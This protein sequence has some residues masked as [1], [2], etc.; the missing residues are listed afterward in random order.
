M[1]CLSC[2]IVRDTESVLAVGDSID[3]YRVGI[4]VIPLHEVLEVPSSCVPI[5][6]GLLEEVV[7]RVKVH[8]EDS[9]VGLIYISDCLFDRI[10]PVRITI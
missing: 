9:F 6:G 10:S 8:E 4:W 2:T 7:V 3:V 1:N 5:E